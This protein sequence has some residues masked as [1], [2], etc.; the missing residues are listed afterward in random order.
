MGRKPF[1][2]EKAELE[3]LTEKM[4]R[5]IEDIVKK[6]TPYIFSIIRSKRQ[7]NY[8]FDDVDLNELFLDI[9]PFLQKELNKGDILKPETIHENLK[10]WIVELI[11]KRLNEY[12]EYKPS[13]KVVESLINIAKKQKININVIDFDTNEK[14]LKKIKEIIQIRDKSVTENQIEYAKSLWSSTIFN[15][16]ILFGRDNVKNKL[17]L[18]RKP[19]TIYLVLRNLEL[20]G[21]EH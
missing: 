7:Y 6:R 1:T 4:K 16:Y 5:E 20:I 2:F 8:D 3:S 19:E 21:I 9:L 12:K 17:M 13:D 18:K 11:S 15:F 14:A 10:I